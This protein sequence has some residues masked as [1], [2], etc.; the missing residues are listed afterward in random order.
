MAN[1]SIAFAPE[2]ETEALRAYFWYENQR[3]GLGENFKICL[4]SGIE[5]LIKNPKTSSYIYKDIRA[6][7][8]RRFPY[9]I[10]YRIF[11]S[12][13]QIVAIFSSLKKS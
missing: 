8:V 10:I 9:N 1:F 4:D 5:S 11:N 2:A 13:I 3:P 6:L 12:Q 7:K